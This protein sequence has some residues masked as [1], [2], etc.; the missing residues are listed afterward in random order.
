MAN[1]TVSDRFWAKVNKTESCWL[2]TAATA[3]G[4]GRFRVRTDKGWAMRG[5]HRWA[6]EAVRGPIPAG[7]VLDHLCRVRS[8]VN[9][10]HLEPVT[11]AVN[12]VRGTGASARNAVKTHCPQGHEYTEENT[13]VVTTT[14][15]YGRVCRACRKLRQAARVTGVGKGGYLAARTHCPR[16]H[17]YEGDNL[18]VGKDGKRRCRACEKERSAQRRSRKSASLE[19]N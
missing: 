14:A 5:A 8:C 4:Y 17:P 15:G 10:D 6:Y 12:I 7:L 13:H 2:W 16:E 19:R 9:P 1:R 3:G 11:H 18:M